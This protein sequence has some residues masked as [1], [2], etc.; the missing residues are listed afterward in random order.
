MAPP[1]V[2]AAAAAAPAGQHS[3]AISAKGTT[4]RGRVRQKSSKRAELLEAG[5]LNPAPGW[6]NAGYIF[7]MGFKS[8]L[9]FRWVVERLMRL[10]GSRVDV[11]GLGSGVLG[12]GVLGSGVLG[13]GVLGSG[14]LGSG[15]RTLVVECAPAWGRAAYALLPARCASLSRA[16]SC[17]CHRMMHTSTA[18]STH[19]HTSAPSPPHPPTTTTSLQVLGGPRRAVHPRVQHPR[20]GGRAVAR[21]YL[22]GHRAGQA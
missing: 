13:S 4:V 20:R 17:H 12:S 5:E 10:A 9:L 18:A 22:C 2:A 1:P 3:R 11:S 19:H 16:A 8:R 15:V 21:A 14:V 7:P 6:Y